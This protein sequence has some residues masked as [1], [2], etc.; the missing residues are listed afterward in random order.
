[1]IRPII[2]RTREEKIRAF[3]EKLARHMTSL[4]GLF[5]DG[6]MLTLIARV[7][8]DAGT[9]SIWTLETADDLEALFAAVIEEMREGDDRGDPEGQEEG[10]EEGPEEKGLIIEP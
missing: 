10:E 1:M 6:T 7:P 2:I 8:G 9:H 4:Q 3:Q 5:I